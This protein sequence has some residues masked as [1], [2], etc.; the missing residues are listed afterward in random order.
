MFCQYELSKNVFAQTFTTFQSCNILYP[1]LW[2]I[3][4]IFDNLD[5]HEDLKEE[6]SLH[7]FN[8][9]VVTDLCPSLGGLGPYTTYE[10]E[11]GLSPALCPRYCRFAF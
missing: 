4:Y 7:F 9:L 2:Q 10:F 11:T 1:R 3:S 8:A 6:V 5:L